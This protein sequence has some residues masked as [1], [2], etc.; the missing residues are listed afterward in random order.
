[1]D[2]KILQDFK[3]NLIS[4]FDELIEQFPNESQFILT[5]IIIKDQVS[6]DFIM[7]YFISS[8]LPCKEMIKSR[9]E[10]FFTDLNVIYFGL[11]ENAASF[12]NLWLQNKLDSDDK[13][14][15]WKWMDLFINLAEK[16]KKLQGH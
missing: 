13:V 15:M 3:S 9:D 12:K 1:M 5:R 10:K 6:P 4:F 11:A 16:Y 14:V 7:N 8:V 2:I